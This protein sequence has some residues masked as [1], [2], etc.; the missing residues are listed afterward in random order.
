MLN[1][2][3]GFRVISV[4]DA[5]VCSGPLR[6]CLRDIGIDS[7]TRVRVSPDEIIVNDDYRIPVEE[8]RRYDSRLP[9]TLPSRGTLKREIALLK[10]LLLTNAA[11]ESLACVL[12]GG[13]KQGSGTPFDEALRNIVHSGYEKLCIGDISSAVIA[14]R[15][16]GF[17]LTPSGDDFLIGLLL[18]LGVRA[19]SEKK[20]LHKTRAFIYDGSLA[21]NM[22]V[23]TL[24]YQSMQKRPDENWR[25]LILALSGQKGLVAAAL[26]VIA[27]GASSGADTLTGFISAWDTNIDGEE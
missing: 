22:L 16:S 11:S 3:H 12:N 1:F 24:L 4:T 23:N 2:I 8:T 14:F 7:I 10:D 27:Q 20:N 17:G 18:G 15:G 25:D 5:S 13:M 21:N 9:M 6:I 26:D 19:I